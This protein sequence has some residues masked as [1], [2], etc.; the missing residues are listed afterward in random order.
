[1]APKKSS[2]VVLALVADLVLVALFTVIGH[3][4]HEKNFDP[5]GLVA[6]AWPFLTGLVVA[7]LLNVVWSAPLAPLRTGVGVWATMIVVGLIIRVLAGQGE[8]AGS[9]PVSFLIV[10][11][12]LNFVTLVGWR[13]IATAAGGRSA[14]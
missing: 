4:T 9:I 10:A 2:H 14:R 12:S 11:A 7:W 3:Y 1:M 6:T 5:Q 8:T 13:V